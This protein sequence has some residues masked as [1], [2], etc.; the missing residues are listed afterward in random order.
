MTFLFC[1][2]NKLWFDFAVLGAPVHSALGLSHWLCTHLEPHQLPCTCNTRTLGLIQRLCVSSLRTNP[3][4]ERWFRGP[5][6]E[7][8]RQPLPRNNPEQL[9][10]T[11]KHLLTP[12]APVPTI[13]LP[14]QLDWTDLPTLRPSLG[15]LLKMRSRVP[16]PAPDRNSRRRLRAGKGSAVE[17]GQPISRTVRELPA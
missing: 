6:A 16:A 14:P 7:D 12:W 4:P 13:H 1:V 8:L 2:G 11:W 5:S 10:Q 3:R 17:T 9:Y 15:Y